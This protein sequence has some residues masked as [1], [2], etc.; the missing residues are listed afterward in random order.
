MRQPRS[1]GALGDEFPYT[2]ATMCYL[3]VGSGG[4]VTYGRDEGT[5]VRVRAGESRLYAVWPG[6]WS[7][8]LFAIDDVEEFGRAFGIVHD[9]DRTGLAD[10]E[11]QVRWSVSPYEDRPSAAYINIDVQFDCGCAIRNLRTF[12]SQ[13]R[14]QRGWD[15]ATSGGWGSHGSDVNGYTYSMRVRRKSLEA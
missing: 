9:E 6:Q 7:S 2:L 15:V 8:D 4:E 12:A 1:A 14:Q 5:Y 11:H 10:H 3:E 13:M